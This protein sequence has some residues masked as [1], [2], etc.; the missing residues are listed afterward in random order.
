[1][2]C[3]SAGSAAPL[4]RDIMA[5][6]DAVQPN[7]STEDPIQAVYML[8][9]VQKLKNLLATERNK[10]NRLLK[11]MEKK[12]LEKQKSSMSA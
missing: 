5:G 11:F 9:D 6:H 7:T 3:P 10:N 4:H 1:M 12:V 8:E 2:A